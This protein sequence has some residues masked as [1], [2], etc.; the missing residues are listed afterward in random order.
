M[1]KQKIIPKFPKELLQYFVVLVLLIAVVIY[2]TFF[3]SIVFRDAGKI[4]LF[5]AIGF[6]SRLPQRL[7][8]FSFG[9]ELVTLVTIVSAILY[10]GLVGAFVGAA[11]FALA[12]FYTHERPQDVLVATVG[13]VLLGW[14]A[15]VAYSFTGSLAL[16]GLLL[17]AVYDLGTNSIYAFSGHNV[18]S[19]L[20][21]SAM[22]IPSNYLI[23]KYLGPVLVNI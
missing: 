17:T 4:M 15:P 7:S 6:G 3:S 20:R 12:G 14:F 2:T 23:L 11:S 19:C 18:L 10:G 22:H 16:T 9:I 13:L 1:T 5:I 21:F 8:Q